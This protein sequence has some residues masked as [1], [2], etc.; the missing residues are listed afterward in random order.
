MSPAPLLV[1]LGPT[2]TGK[3]DLGIAVAERL[4]GEVVNAD[5]MQ[6]YRGMDV[7]TAK[8][9]A[10]RRRV[11]HHQLDVLDVT[12]EATLA[13]YQ[14]AARA[15]VDA[16]RARGGVPVLVGGSGLY[17]RA[18]T[19]DLVIPPTDA[20]VRARLEA[21]A[22]LFDWGG[23]LI[24]ALMPEGT[25]LQART[26]ITGVTG[27]GTTCQSGDGAYVSPTIAPPAYQLGDLVCFRLDMTFPQGVSTRSVNVSDY[28]PSGMSIVDWAATSANSTTITP[29][30][31][32]T[33]VASARWVLGEP[34]ASN[35]LFV[36]PGATGSFYLLA[37]VN[38]VPATAPRVAGNLAKMRYTGP[39]D[40]VINL[41]DQADLK[42]SPPPPL[43]LDKKVDGAESLSP[44]QEG[45]LLT[46]TI[47]VS[48]NGSLAN[49]TADPIDEIEV[50]DVLPAGFDC[51]DI[52]SATPAINPIA[53]CFQQANGQTRVTWILRPATPL[54]GGQTATITYALTVPSPLSISSS[55]TNT[56]AVTRYTPITTDGITPSVDRP[57]FY[58][59]NP[60]GAYPDKTKNA[61]QAADTATISLAGASVAKSVTSTSVTESNN[62]ALTQATIGETVV[63][64]YTATIPARTSIFNGIL[65]DAAPFDT[66][67]VRL[68]P[69]LPEGVRVERV[70][71]DDCGGG[72]SHP[73][74]A[75][76]L[77]QR[78]PD[79][80]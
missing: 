14:A 76:V 43:G 67:G 38:T 74:P 12:Q 25:D 39:D 34:D 33:G 54:I 45:Q 63:W 7:G 49:S 3:S 36:E 61:P 40:R 2:A 71:R 20:D 57:T 41:R 32:V 5:A 66:A 16:I 8:V 77:R 68:T 30:G 1:V 69:S 52:D 10:D 11:P 24:W 27:V 26:P 23:G 29:V 15:D 70:A 18:V 80:R 31:T 75:Y 50:W 42:L 78:H 4:G 48:H 21:E 60:V 62:S 44:V 64:Q 28:L 46:F 6:L 58:P 13:G 79:Q 59:A 35:V 47:D 37:R 51:D 56:A 9:P 22:L 17:L 19:D 73:S 53:D 55:H 65:A 72:D